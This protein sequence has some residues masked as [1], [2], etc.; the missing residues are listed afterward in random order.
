V[1]AD[2]KKVELQAINPLL[3]LVELVREELEEACKF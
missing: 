3:A 1:I 2:E